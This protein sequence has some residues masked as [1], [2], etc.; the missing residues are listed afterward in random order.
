MWVWYPGQEGGTGAS[1]QG[2]ARLARVA[3]DLRREEYNQAKISQGE[4]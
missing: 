1:V 4:Y 3:Q 2:R